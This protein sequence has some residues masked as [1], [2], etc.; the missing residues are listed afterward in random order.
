MGIY[1]GDGVSM[2]GYAYGTAEC[3]LGVTGVARFDPGP[4]SIFFVV[5]GN[6]GL[7]EGSYGLRNPGDERPEAVGLPGCDYPQDLANRCDP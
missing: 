1:H 7:V 2:S 6:N 3:G 4:G 5:V